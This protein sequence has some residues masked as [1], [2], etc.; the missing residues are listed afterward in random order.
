M[1]MLEPKLWFMGHY[2]KNL[3]YTLQPLEN[4]D[5]SCHCVMVDVNCVYD[6]SQHF[7]EKILDKEE[8]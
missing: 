4:N 5:Y 3:E 8:E 6:F 1:C 2:H 7:S